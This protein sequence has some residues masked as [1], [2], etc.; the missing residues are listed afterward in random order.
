[1]NY[2]ILRFYKI[3]LKNSWL[4]CKSITFCAC[5]GESSLCILKA[6]KAIIEITWVVKSLNCINLVQRPA[7]KPT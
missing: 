4:L 6:K 3:L 1:M 7:N 2:A 5:F